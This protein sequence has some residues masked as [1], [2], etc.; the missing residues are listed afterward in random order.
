MRPLSE[1]CRN[2]LKNALT[3][4]ERAFDLVWGAVEPCEEREKA[5]IHLHFAKNAINVMLDAPEQPVTEMGME[6]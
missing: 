5:R 6:E 2:S 1:P 4:V 3:H